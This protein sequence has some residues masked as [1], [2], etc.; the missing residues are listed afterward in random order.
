[1]REW[2]QELDEDQ[3]CDDMCLPAP[4]GALWSFGFEWSTIQV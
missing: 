4:V 1:M 3:W 2:V